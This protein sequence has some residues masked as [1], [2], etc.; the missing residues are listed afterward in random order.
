[1]IGT[2]HTRISTSSQSLTDIHQTGKLTIRAAER[3]AKVCADVGV[4]RL[5][6]VS[7]LNA[8]PDSA[9]AF[10]RSKHAGERAVRDAFPE[11]T[12]VRPAGLY[13]PEDWLLN[14]MARE[15]FTSTLT[16][17]L[18]YLVLTG[19]IPNLVQAEWRKHQ[20]PS[21]PCHGRSR[22]F[23]R[24]ADRSR[25]IYRIH[26]RPPRTQSP[27]FQLNPQPGQRNDNETR[28]FSSN[29]T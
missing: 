2:F 16:P 15:S 11:A 18:D 29:T 4:P 7:H 13:G 23:M 22:S 21:C 14:A 17:P 9:S 3:I 8:S 24:N 28:L 6:H 1:M 26:I 20:N 19:R 25:H 27:H 10:Y 12:I 5:I